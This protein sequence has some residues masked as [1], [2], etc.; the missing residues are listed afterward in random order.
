MEWGCL[1][2]LSV[3]DDAIHQSNS[4]GFHRVDELPRKQKPTRASF[5][6]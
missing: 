6:D 3:R 2:Q 5:T 1:L 4:L